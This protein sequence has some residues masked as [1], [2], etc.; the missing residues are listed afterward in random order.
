M[1]YQPWVKDLNANTW[2]F[3]PWVRVAGTDT[4]PWTVPGEVPVQFEPD[5]LNPP[6]GPGKYLVVARYAWSQWTGSSWTTWTMRDGVPSQYINL[7]SFGGFYFTIGSVCDTI[8]DPGTVVEITSTSAQR[9]ITKLSQRALEFR[10]PSMPVASR[11]SPAA[12]AKVAPRCFGVRP[13]IVGTEGADVLIGTPHRDVIVGLGGDDT[14]FGGGSGRDFICAGA[15]A[16][17]VLGGSGRDRIAGNRGDD[18]LLGESAA[19]TL[20]GGQGIDYI[21]P[22]PGRDEADGGGPPLDVISYL[23][24]SSAVHVDFS[25]GMA[26]GEGKD[27]FQRINAVVGSNGND[28][29]IGSTGEEL[30]VPV[31]GNDN[32]DGELGSDAILYAL[33]PQGVIVNLAGGSSLGE[34]SDTLAGLEVVSGSPLDDVITGDARYNWLSG[35]DGNDQLDGLVGDDSLDGGGGVDICVNGLTYLGCENQGGDVVPVPSGSDPP[36]IEEPPI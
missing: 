21:E 36:L 8:G 34:G 19:D 7:E 26:V 6:Q 1:Y 3:Y 17:G 33:S 29:L 10:S 9:R 12:A 5:Y 22:G 24:S 13:T 35:G 18:V 15:G 20:K 30:F 11:L 23:A 2:T 28:S 31:G 4:H 32:V 16:D 25:T 14:I 27:R